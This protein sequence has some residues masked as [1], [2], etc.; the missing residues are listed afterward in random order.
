MSSEHIDCPPGVELVGPFTERRL[1]VDGWQVPFLDVTEVDGGR[2]HF[3]LDKRLGFDVGAA[4][5]EQVAH[6]VANCI[7]VASGLPCHPRGD[8]TPEER[9]AAFAHATVHWTL[10]PRRTVGIEMVGTEEEAERDE[11][12]DERPEGY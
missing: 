1:I 9:T 11:Q 2:V 3:T 7:A 12:D 5:F 4:D 8:L 10:L 6:L